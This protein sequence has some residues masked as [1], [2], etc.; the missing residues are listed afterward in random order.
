MTPDFPHNIRIRLAQLKKKMLRPDIALSQFRKAK[1]GQPIGQR[2]SNVRGQ[3]KKSI[4]P[5]L[6]LC[7]EES[8][9]SFEFKT[10]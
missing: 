3:Q 1:L 9:A 10:T 8:L 7:Y 4:G 5:I 2:L 6:P